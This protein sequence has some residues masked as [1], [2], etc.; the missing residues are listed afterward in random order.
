MSRHT[1]RLAADAAGITE[2]AALLRA[3]QLVAFPTETV[4]GLGA[5]AT[6]EAAVAAIYAAKTRPSFNPLIAHYATAAAAFDD[7]T[8]TALGER[9]AAAFWP[10][11]LTLVL[12]RRPRAAVAR[13]AGAGLDTQAV[14]V[15]AHEVARQLLAAVGRPV[16]APSA[17]PSGR[18]SPTTAQHVLDGLDGRIA[19]VIDGGA[20]AV[21]LES[22]VIDLS[23]RRP[24]LL[25][26]GGITLE[27]L[28][29]VAPEITAGDSHD[30]A[31]PRSP[32]QLL[33]HYAPDLP[34]RLNAAAVGE[35][36]ALLAFGAPLPGAALVFNLS[37]TGD[38]A[39]AAARLFA[40]LRW[41]DAQGRARGLTAIA[42]MEIPRAGLGL[43]IQDRLSRA[44]HGAPIKTLT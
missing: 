15:P 40:G 23:G 18:V 43:A 1:I 29:A 16:A 27:A 33:S 3:G 35:T 6:D 19:A 34:L 2:A 39:E 30:A 5:D 4:Y 26:A 13:L 44:A 14:R 21:G 20:C 24:T 28:Q 17:N 42:A 8:P 38:L 36:E 7:V 31:A 22:T 25:R 37:E 11:P 10:G 9:L 32:G 12:P 41:L